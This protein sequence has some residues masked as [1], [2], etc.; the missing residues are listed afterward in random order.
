MKKLKLS[1]ENYSDCWNCKKI[2]KYSHNSEK[3]WNFIEN[4]L[5]ISKID[6]IARNMYIVQFFENIMKIDQNASDILT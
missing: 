2:I 6:K 5:K 1:W 3:K 4:L